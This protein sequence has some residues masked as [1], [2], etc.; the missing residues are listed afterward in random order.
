MKAPGFSGGLS[1][2]S[3]IR[4]QQGGDLISRARGVQLIG[5]GRGTLDG[6][7]PGRGS[8]IPGQAIHVVSDGVVERPVSGEEE[9]RL[10]ASAFDHREHRPLGEREGCGVVRPD[11]A[12]AVVGGGPDLAVAQLGEL[13]GVGGQ[14]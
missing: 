5:R 14:S 7:I 9:G 11:G 12:S 2:R 8:A 3:L 10:A 4:R 13:G 1:L 6:D